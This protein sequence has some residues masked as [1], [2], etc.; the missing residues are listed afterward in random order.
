VVITGG[1][2]GIGLACAEALAAVGRPA[3]VAI[4][5]RFLLSDQASYITATELVVDGG[6]ISS[7]RQ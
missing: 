2:S 6:N 4:A 3:E 7:Q 1:A 5:V